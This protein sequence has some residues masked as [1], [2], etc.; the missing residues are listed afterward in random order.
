MSGMANQGPASQTRQ[1]GSC[2][3]SF[4]SRFGGKG[5]PCP[6]CCAT[7]GCFSNPAVPAARPFGSSWGALART[8]WLC[9]PVY[10][11]PGPTQILFSLSSS[12]SFLFP[13]FLTF[14]FL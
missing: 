4:L 14:P 13:S 11:L 3:T 8:D 10:G 2:T 6:L 1:I 7:P 5:T 9:C 12:L